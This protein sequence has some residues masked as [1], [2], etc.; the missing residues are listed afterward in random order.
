MCFLSHNKKTKVDVSFMI[1]K[2][3]YILERQAKGKKQHILCQIRHRQCDYSN[4]HKI[5]QVEQ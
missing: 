4:I 5:K 1:I 2:V 3:C